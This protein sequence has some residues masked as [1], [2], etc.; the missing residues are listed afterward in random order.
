MIGS[1]TIDALLTSEGHCVLTVY[2]KRTHISLGNVIV[3]TVLSIFSVFHAQ[4]IWP[5]L[6]GIFLTITAGG[7]VIAS[8]L[9]CLGITVEVLTL[10]N[11]VTTLHIIVVFTVLVLVHVLLGSILLVLAGVLIEVL[12]S[13]EL[14]Q[15]IRILVIG[16]VQLTVHL[17]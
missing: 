17:R 7:Q 10:L 6:L 3:D 16:L 13:L 5:G 8:I 9:Q 4:T 14:N 15:K 12:L 1:R 11:T 2:S